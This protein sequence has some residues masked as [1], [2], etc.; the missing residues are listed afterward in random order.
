MNTS[1]KSID[2]LLSYV[3]DNTDEII[4]S[5]SKEEIN[6][7]EELEDFLREMVELGLLKIVGQDEDGNDLYEAV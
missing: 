5:I 3:T 1:F 2:D 7:I 6:S 4:D